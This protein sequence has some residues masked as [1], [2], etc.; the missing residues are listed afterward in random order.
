MRILLI[1]RAGSST[2]SPHIKG[3]HMKH[4]ALIIAL[5]ISLSA[6]ANETATARI[7]GRIITTGM[8][9]AEVAQRAGQPSR[10]VQ[11]Q[12]GYGGAVGERWEYWIKG[13]QIN[14][15]IQGSK[16]VRIDEI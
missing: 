2:M 6:Y 3:A 8:S 10:T 13:K 15:T 16:V 4:I 5:L 14:L 11:L 12:N 9:V 7:N 1:R